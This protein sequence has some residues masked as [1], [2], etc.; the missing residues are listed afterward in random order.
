M[1]KEK[2]SATSAI[3]S[4]RSAAR[5]VSII[6]PIV[7][8]QAARHRAS[9][10]SATALLHPAAGERAAPR[11]LTVSG[12]MI[13]TIGLL[14]GCARRSRGRLDER[15][16]LHRVEAGL[17]DAE[18][19]AARAEH[20]VVLAP[21]LGGREQVG[22]LGR[23]ARCVAC[24][25]RSSSTDGQELVQRRVEQPD[26]DGQPVHRLEDL[27]RSRSAGRRAAPRARPP[28][29]PACRRGSS[30]R[31]I[32]RRSSPRNMCSVRHRPMPSA[33]NSRA[34]LRVRAG[35]GVGPHAELALADLVGPAED[36]VELRRRL[37]ARRA[38][39]RR[40]RPRR[41]V[42]SMEM[43]SPSCTDRRRRP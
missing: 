41:C 23:Q 16:H 20:R 33:P 39:P 28:P 43:T 38:P 13:S 37:G 19:H 5:G 9:S 3:S 42:P 1:P 6:V 14:A 31:T 32:G 29:R 12:I 25:T 24:L 30:A 21:R 4:A 2:K 17:H 34:L 40:A 27:R 22:L 11:R 7:M 18:P 15:P 26:G 8:S 35:V 10:R 36:R